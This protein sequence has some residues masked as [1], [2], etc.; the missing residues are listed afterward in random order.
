LG[1]MVD[2]VFMTG[3]QR[4]PT[5]TSPMPASGCASFINFDA[6]QP[7]IIDQTDPVICHRE[8]LSFAFTLIAAKQLPTNF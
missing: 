4:Y 3:R 1:Q 2:P 5:F 7:W 8:D 6:S